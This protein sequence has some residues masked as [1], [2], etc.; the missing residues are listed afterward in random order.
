MTRVC[1]IGRRVG[2]ALFL[3]C[4]ATGCDTAP[5]CGEF[6]NYPYEGT[7]ELTNPEDSPV[8][9]LSV[10]VVCN[11]MTFRYLDEDGEEQWITYTIQDATKD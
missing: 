3:S 11:E 9:I 8:E 2:P 10:E 5:A 1:C 4:I 6:P 7:Y